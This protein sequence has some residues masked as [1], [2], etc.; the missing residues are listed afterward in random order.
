MRKVKRMTEK[1]NDSTTTTNKD[2]FS[3][4]II[5]LSIKD[6]AKYFILKEIK[7][8]VKVVIDRRVYIAIAMPEKVA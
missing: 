8:K 6:K 5:I 4:I 1:E 2:I 7:R 3:N